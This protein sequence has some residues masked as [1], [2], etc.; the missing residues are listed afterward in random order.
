MSDAATAVS[1]KKRGK[2]PQG[3]RSKV[4][5]DPVDGPAA[6]EAECACSN[7]VDSGHELIFVCGC[8]DQ[9]SLICWP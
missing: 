3:I 2:R 6:D 8:A 1:F 4:E 9:W 7:M 5:S